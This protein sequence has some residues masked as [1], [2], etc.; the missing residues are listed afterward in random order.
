MLS[1]SK[2]AL[3]QGHNHLL[4]TGTDDLTDYRERHIVTRAS[5]VVTWWIVD[6]LRSEYYHAVGGVGLGLFS[7]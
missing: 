6:F 3:F 5:I 2:N 4:A 7:L 1:P